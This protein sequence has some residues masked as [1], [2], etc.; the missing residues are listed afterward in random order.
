[1]SSSPASSRGT[2][3]LIEP[4]GKFFQVGAIG[5]DRVVGEPRSSQR[6]SRNGRSG[7]GILLCLMVR[8]AQGNRSPL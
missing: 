3:L 7:D 2:A 4:E 8:R 1:M 5:A 6:A